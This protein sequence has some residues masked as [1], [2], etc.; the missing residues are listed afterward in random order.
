MP[1]SVSILI[2]WTVS[3]ANWCRTTGKSGESIRQTRISSPS[4][5]TRNA[6]SALS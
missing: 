1:A 4:D 6:P 3:P 2:S 5:A